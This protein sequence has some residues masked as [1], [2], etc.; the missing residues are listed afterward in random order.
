MAAVASDGRSMPAHPLARAVRT[1]CRSSPP[2]P[3]VP[4]VRPWRPTRSGAADCLPLLPVVPGGQ[5]SSRTSWMLMISW[6]SCSESVYQMVA[7]EVE[8]VGTWQRI[9]RREGVGQ[10][11]DRLIEQLEDRAL[12]CPSQRLRQCLDLLPRLPGK[13]TARSLTHRFPRLGKLLVRED[14]RVIAWPRIGLHVCLA[15]PRPT[16]RRSRL[17]SAFSPSSSARRM[18]TI[19]DASAL[20]HGSP[21]LRAHS[22]V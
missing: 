11:R 8:Y 10:G 6:P 3:A 12:D 9:I 20:T 19:S 15:T 21:Q 1:A 14:R 13:R 2:M 16:S 5:V 4:G 18:V 22:R 7:G 17:S